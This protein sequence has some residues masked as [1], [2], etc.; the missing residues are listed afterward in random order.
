[1]VTS[2]KTNTADKCLQNDLSKSCLHS[3]EPE[4]KNLILIL[5]HSI[6]SCCAKKQHG[7]I[8][9]NNKWCS[10]YVSAFAMCPFYICSVLLLNHIFLQKWSLNYKMN[11]FVTFSL[12]LI[13]SKWSWIKA[14]CFVVSGAGAVVVLRDL[15]WDCRLLMRVHLCYAT[16]QLCKML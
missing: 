6:W 5:A 15:N 13:V 4:R 1:V 10:I 7:K 8:T 3:V 2:L 12:L 14:S 9:R 16:K 11:F